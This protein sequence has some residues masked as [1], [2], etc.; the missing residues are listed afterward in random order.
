MK[1]I[2]D[3]RKQVYAESLRT[4]FKTEL[5]SLDSIER[6]LVNEAIDALALA[7]CFQKPRSFAGELFSAEKFRSISR[8]ISF[9][10]LCVAV[11]ALAAAS[12]RVKNRIW[13]ILGVLVQAKGSD[14][15]VP[16]RACAYKN[17]KQSDK[18]DFPQRTYTQEDFNSIVTNIDDLT[19]KDL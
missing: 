18:F 19:D 1:N 8:N 2:L 17:L 6:K 9:E 14:S 5:A 7:C 10:T 15:M 4:R 3:I 13:Y 16:K 12:R 11:Q